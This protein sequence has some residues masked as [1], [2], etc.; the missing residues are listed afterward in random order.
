M[1]RCSARPDLDSDR[2]R[3][4]GELNANCRTTFSLVPSPRPPDSIKGV[5]E[6][7]RLFSKYLGLVRPSPSFLRFH[8][9]IY[10]KNK[11]NIVII[12]PRNVVDSSNCYHCPQFSCS[13]YCLMCW[14]CLLST[15]SKLMLDGISPLYNYALSA[16]FGSRDFGSLFSHNY[17]NASIKF[18]FV[19]S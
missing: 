7:S 2:P 18:R 8:T 15:D 19:S 3:R 1:Q 13:I 14:D 5:N 12:I 4:S 6:F 11:E 17:R 10:Y 9:R 16:R